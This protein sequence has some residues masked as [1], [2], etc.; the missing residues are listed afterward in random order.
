MLSAPQ[1]SRGQPLSCLFL[2]LSLLISGGA[3][4]QAK[5]NPPRPGLPKTAPAVPVKSVPGKPVPVKPVPVQPGPVKA[6]PMPAASSLTPVPTY[7]ARKVISA[8]SVADNG[9]VVF[10]G[11]DARL[12]RLDAS[13]KERWAFPLGDIGRASPVLTPQ[14]AAIAV[15]YDDS[16]YSID[17]L[18][19]KLWSVRL[20]GGDIYASPALRPD[21]SLIVAV[22]G[23]VIYALSAQGQTLWTYRHSS[24][25]YSSPVVAP[26]GAVYLGTQGNA[27]IALSPDGKLLWTYGVGSTVFSS[28]ALDNSGNLYFGS[29]DKK[30]YSLSAQGKL[31]WTRATGSF[32][33][34]SPIVTAAG[35]VVVGSYDGKVYAL[36][37]GGQDAWTYAASAPV[38]APAAELTGGAVVVGD[39]GGTLHAIAPGGQVI[40][41]LKTGEKIDT[42]VNVSPA[43]TLYFATASGR[44]GSIE[45]QPPLADGAWSYFRG[46]AAGYGRLLSPAES[47][48]QVAL[49]RPAAL[50]AAPLLAR[51]AAALALVAQAPQLPVQLTTTQPPATQPTTIPII[52]KPPAPV[53]LKIDPAMA[54]A[55]ARQV[56]V[57]SGQLLLP[58]PELLGALG[59]RPTVQTP[60]S[61]SFVLGG[62]VLTL[63][64]RTLDVAGKSGAW[65]ALADLSRLKLGGKPG[66]V[67]YTAKR[68]TLQLGAQ[69]PL[70]LPLDL[71]KLLPFLP[72]REF[73][74]VIERPAPK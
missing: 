11:S 33:N 74:N 9:D 65:L 44:L 23:G 36:T 34:A 26:D 53:A 19:K 17:A 25:I 2:T 70:T 49:K 56:Q 38:A 43:G 29:G 10:I 66:S 1:G 6:A 64:L 61:V 60:R 48:A 72:V 40:W 58:L 71:P 31:R 4:A 7:S 35:L 59:V 32:V 27:V 41:T 52:P 69:V 55:A 50:K 24:P 30:I 63:P 15:A 57:V 8:I 45:G 5:V 73:S 20:E 42:S 14:G 28:P 3:S 37:Q 62:E 18:G 54:L 46:S 21:G 16:V 68:Y 51:Q 22:S 12:H 67:R 39:L 13:G 47:A